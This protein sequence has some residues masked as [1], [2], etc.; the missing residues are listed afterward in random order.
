MEHKKERGPEEL[1]RGDIMASVC[2]WRDA[3]TALVE[4]DNLL[5]SPKTAELLRSLAD[6][7]D[8]FVA[9]FRAMATLLDLPNDTLPF[10]WICESGPKE[11]KFTAQCEHL[12]TAMA[13][14]L[15]LK[16]RHSPPEIT[17]Q[18]KAD[19]RFGVPAPLVVQSKLFLQGHQS[20]ANC[21]R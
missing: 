20:S 2:H 5:Q 17:V 13:A 16:F 21:H 4:W 1:L 12:A 7:M 18:Q 6:D 3:G 19:M 15:L 9:Y 8:E 14:M 11:L 10:I